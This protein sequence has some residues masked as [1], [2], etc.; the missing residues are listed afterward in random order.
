MKSCRRHSLC[1]TAIMFGF[2]TIWASHALAVDSEFSYF[3]E[4]KLDYWKEGSRSS[5]APVVVRPA[6]APRPSGDSKPT[7]P[8][9]Q[10]GGETFQWQKYLDP[11]ND[12]FFREGEYT[13]PAP[14]ME[15]ARNPTDSNIENWFHYLETKNQLL[16]RLQDKLTAY[17]ANHGGGLPPN[18]P[19]IPP[20]MAGAVAGASGEA[21]AV[22]A[23][24]A[25]QLG[26]TSAPRPDAKRFRLR[27][28][29]DCNWPAV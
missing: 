10:A 12:D 27:L 17:T 24:A 1:S 8:P 22:V 19:G 25:A 5:E 13:P 21:P 11:K 26:G 23:R 18:M 3:S 28:Y 14:F 6:G 15:I 20:E 4:P 9:A 2:I 7:N 29:F 16:R